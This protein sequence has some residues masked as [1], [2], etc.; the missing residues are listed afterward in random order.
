MSRRAVVTR[1]VTTGECDWLPQDIIAG[2]ILYE[3]EGYTYG[4]IEEGV[5][6][7]LEEDK[8]PFFEFP[9]EALEFVD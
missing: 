7:T 8:T 4:C 3:Y 2:T 9:K 6:V 1:D 5:A